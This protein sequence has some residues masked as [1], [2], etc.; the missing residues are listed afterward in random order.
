M[1]A[2]VCVCVR[3]CV[4]AYVPL[5]QQPVVGQVARLVALLA[6]VSVLGLHRVRGQQHRRL[7]GAV[8]LIVQDGLLHL[9]EEEQEEEE[10]E[11]EEEEE[12]IGNMSDIKPFLIC[13]AASF[14]LSEELDGCVRRCVRSV[15]GRGQ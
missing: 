1:R 4:C 6:V 13:P 12:S 3:V 15:R 11:E 10:Q 5:G 9:Q 14:E 7:R 8:V 2:C